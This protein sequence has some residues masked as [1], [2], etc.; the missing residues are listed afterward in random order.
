M[1]KELGKL[2]NR[3]QADLCVSADGAWNICGLGQRTPRGRMS[4]AGGTHH[5][6]K[7]C[8]AV[9]RSRLFH[10]SGLGNHASTTTCFLDV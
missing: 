8:I 4:V 7:T 10:M 5:L 2:A 6:K 9:D 1:T 3:W